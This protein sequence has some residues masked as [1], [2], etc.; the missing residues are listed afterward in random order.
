MAD[1][2]NVSF[3]RGTQT[4]L[5]G[6]T[7]YQPGAFYLTTDTDRLYFAQS[8][9][10]LAYL[11]RYITTVNTKDDLPALSSVSVGDFYY[12]A[13]GNILC[14]KD[15]A[16]AT[17]WTQINPPDTDTDTSVDGLTFST[18][19]KDSN[20][21]V[22]YTL[23]QKSKNTISGS[24]L[25]V[26][27]EALTGTFIIK[28]SDIG[29]VVTNIALDTKATVKDNV[30]TIELEG[31]GVAGDADGFTIAAGA[32]VSIKSDNTNDVVIEAVDTTY[33][34]GSDANSTNITLKNNLTGT[35]V[36]VAINAGTSNDSIAIDGTEKDKIIVKHK[37]F[38]AIDST[39]DE[40]VA[41]NGGSFT[42]VSGVTTDNGHVTKVNTSTV[43]LPTITYSISAVNADSD[44]KVH[45]TLTQPNGN[46]VTTSSGA[47]LYYTIKGEEIYNQG[48]LGNY[49]YTKEEIDTTLQSANAMTFIGSVGEGG[50][51]GTSLPVVAD[52]VKAGDTYIV[53]G[54]NLV[55]GG[56]EG[57]LF[58]ASGEEEN[59]YLTEIEWVHVPAGDEIDTTYTF[60][61]EAGKGL[62]IKDH[63]SIEVAALAFKGDKDVNPDD[64]NAAINITTNGEVIVSH[65]DVTRQNTTGT[66]VTMN[67]DQKVNVI[68][69]VTT[70]TKGHVTGVE[71]TELVMP[72]EVSYRVEGNANN[73]AL[74]KDQDGQVDGTITIN[75]GTKVNVTSSGNENSATFTVE[76]NTMEVGAGSA[77][78]T[79][80]AKNTFTAITGIEDDGYGHMSKI[81]TTTYT[82]PKD[83]TYTLSG[84][85]VTL[86]TADDGLKTISA[87][88]TL[89]DDAGKTS[90]ST[91]A[92][93]SKSL[94][95][96]V[97][98][99]VVNAELTWGTF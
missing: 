6:L 95:M 96:S 47:N 14:T 50:S 5:N 54:S 33:T 17:A 8:A 97:S 53:V 19:A 18:V 3:L 64:A 7:T 38:T 34:F 29:S 68:T 84:D 58:I 22:S 49:F 30:A 11:N 63:R 86:T 75:G 72:A 77:S 80:D 41:E 70:N 66:S 13:N 98:N 56:S 62:V 24:D 25:E 40:Q 59:G 94:N 65:A 4:K 12:V 73:Q 82:L 60:A 27:P 85:I 28:G 87:V 99:N 26:Q 79:L 76:H 78:V 55:N 44:G 46:P 10:K 45:V 42:I 39:M 9:S 21:E 67:G 83:S 81:T 23:T 32:N 88:S 74:L 15:N 35:P 69:G 57:D 90:T 16:S 52:K 2:L 20:I 31:T 36:N 37:D 93:S 51:K 92:L 43:K 91:F 71:T 89:T 61:L 48:E 1:T